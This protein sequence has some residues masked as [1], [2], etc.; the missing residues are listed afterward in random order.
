M[1]AGLYA[2]SV[3]GCNGLSPIVGASDHVC[4]ANIFLLPIAHG[5]L[6]GVVKLHMR[7]ILA[8]IKRGDPRPP[9]VLENAAKRIIR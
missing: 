6:L 8:D 2:P 5:L 4:Y 1:D 9:Y 7:T 3:I